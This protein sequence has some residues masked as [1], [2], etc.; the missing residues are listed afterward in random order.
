MV[1]KSVNIA[2]FKAE[3]SRYL[4]SVRKGEEV[5]ITDRDRPV[6]KVVPISEPA[7]FKLE[8]RAALVDPAGLCKLNFPPLTGIKVN[9]L[10]YLLQER[11][12]QR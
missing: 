3:L 11:Q 8:V 12:S 6:A 7:P 1:M 9:S 2:K 10:E 5:V 4:R